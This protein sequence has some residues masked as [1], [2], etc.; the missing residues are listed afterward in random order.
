MDLE[1]TFLSSHQMFH[2]S[3]SHLCTRIVIN[4]DKSNDKI[5]FVEMMNLSYLS[6][7]FIYIKD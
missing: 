6:L 2:G 4:S 1:L 3:Q 5:T 7:Y